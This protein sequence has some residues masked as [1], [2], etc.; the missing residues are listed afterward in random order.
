MPPSRHRRRRAASRTQRRT[1]P[2]A[3]GGGFNS[4]WLLVAFAVIAVVFIVALL[5]PVLLPLLGNPGGNTGNANEYIPG[6]GRQVEIADSTD[7]FP[8]TLSIT[9]VSPD[10][11]LTTPP[12]SGRHWG[13]WVRCGFY[14]DPVPDERIVHNMEHGNIIVHYNFDDPAQVDRLKD[15]YDSIG[16]T[17][18]WGVAR[19]YDRIPVGAVAL[20]TWGVMDG[21]WDASGDYTWDGATWQQTTPGVMDRPWDETDTARMERFFEAYSGKLGPEFPNGAPCTRGGVMNP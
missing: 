2:V 7:H 17:G 4:M 10:G 16:Q 11:Y 6:I 12:T 20:T 18:Q 13:Q 1:Q 21:P 3:S 9:A 5:V 15:A 19:P 14:T 8:N